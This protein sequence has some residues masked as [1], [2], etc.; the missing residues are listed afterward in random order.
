MSESEVGMGRVQVEL[1]LGKSFETEVL[2]RLAHRYVHELDLKVKKRLA[3][4]VDTAVATCVE[5]EIRP[6]V[7]GI[8]EEGWQRTNQWGEVS[9]G[10]VGLRERIGELL[11]KRGPHTSATLVEKLARE[12]LEKALRADF[13]KELAEAQKK[14]RALFDQEL[15]GKVQKVLREGLGL[16]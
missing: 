13:G 16:R 10:K 6:V 9:G 2:E 4:A 14:V 1:E 11:N 5:E 3:A 8:L 15:M 12:I 7:R